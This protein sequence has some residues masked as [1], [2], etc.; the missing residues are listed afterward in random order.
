MSDISNQ[1]YRDLA[2]PY[3]IEVFKIVDEVLKANDAPYYLIG[4][5]A[6]DIQLLKEGIKPSRGTKD[7]DFAVMVSSFAEYEKIKNDLVE[8]GFNPVKDPFTL[9]HPDYNVAIDLLPFGQIEQSDTMNFTERE[10]TMNVLGFKETLE[11]PN[12]VALDETLSIQVPPL[13]GMVMLKLIS[14]FDRPEIRSD[15]L[16]DIFRIV[17]HYFDTDGDSIFT[18]HYDLLDAEP[19]DQKLIAAEV[20]GRRISSI[21]QKSKLLRERVMR[22][23][24][25][26]TSEPAK[27]NIGKHWAS[28]YHINVDY[29][30][31]ILNSIKKGI[32]KNL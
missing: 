24:D 29:A 16:G 28:R 30:I 3:F 1:T 15:D 27:S 22:V 8:K 32:N 18:D 12:E 13:H 14:W 26:N 21:L 7:I 5:T 17:S 9:Y 19:F 23:L 25:E 20:M 4:V 10:V 31:D 2:I 11:H 6:T